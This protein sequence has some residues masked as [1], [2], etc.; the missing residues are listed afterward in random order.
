MARTRRDSRLPAPFLKRVWLDPARIEDS[1][2]YPFCLPVFRSGDF[3]LA[4]ERPITIIVGE[5][6]SG[7]ST[8]LEGIAALAG[9]DQAGGG[10]GY[11]P[12]DHSRSIEATAEPLG[13]ALRA[14][15]LP[16][17]TE[18]WF[19]RAESFFSVARYLD[20]AAQEPQSGPPPDYLSHS[21]G[22]GFLR[23]F[24]ERCQ[25]RGIYI[26]D[27]PESALSPARQIE[28]LKLLRRMEQSGDAQV[29]IAT[30]AP[31]LMA[32]PEAELLQLGKYG[33]ARARL[34]EL[35]HFRLMREF[36]SDPATFVATMLEM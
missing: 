15:W 34:E 17:V 28:F 7:K 27:E 16:K 36:F 1:D 22:E 35:D 25:R 21:H 4:F 26:F 32:Y 8:L 33:L 13:R 9:Y 5:N 23:F 20:L 29:L 2:A 6:G 31:L 10:K 12:V 24:E 14:S 19:F 18:G 30:H 3:E 11:R